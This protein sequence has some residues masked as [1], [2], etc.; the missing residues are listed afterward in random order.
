MMAISV[1]SSVELLVI[2]SPQDQISS[3]Q[4]RGDSFAVSIRI[5]FSSKLTTVE[6]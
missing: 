5:S 1:V 3:L 2:H 6:K 4:R